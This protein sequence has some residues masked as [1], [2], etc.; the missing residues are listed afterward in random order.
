[1]NDRPREARPGRPSTRSESGSRGFRWR[2]RPAA[3]RRC[4]APSARR[5]RRPR[6]ARRGCRCR[7]CRNRCPVRPDSGPRGPESRAAD[8]A[9]APGR[10]AR[11]P[12]G[13]HRGTTTLA[14]T[15][16][17]T[18]RGSPIST[19]TSE[20]SRTRAAER[21]G[22]GGPRRIVGEQLAVFLHRR[23]AAGGVDDDPI[24][25]GAVEGGDQPSREGARLVDPSGVERQR[26][27]APLIGRRDHLAPFG[28]QHVDRRA[29]DVREHEA[30]HAA[31][32]QTD[33][34]P[35]RADGGGVFGSAAHE[36]RPRDRA[37]RARAARAGAAAA[38]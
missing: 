1:M 25:P 18:A 37:A 15:G 3:A 34:Q 31:G 30:L 19:S 8:R 27:A 26:A 22:A 36:R 38:A 4:S 13:R 35:L 23:P 21:V 10:P 9:A 11:A 32:Q 29:V 17:R 6:P 28:G 2:P 12:D 33:L 5:A 14:W 7:R 24:D 16:C 20:T